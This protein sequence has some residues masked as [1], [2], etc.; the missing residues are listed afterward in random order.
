M[1]IG[2]GSIPMY[3]YIYMLPPAMAASDVRALHVYEF[4]EEWNLDGYQRNLTTTV[5][6]WIKDDKAETCR[7]TFNAV[8]CGNVGYMHDDRSECV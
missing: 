4:T 5:V 1:S 7:L 6:K 8:S 2:T 3:F